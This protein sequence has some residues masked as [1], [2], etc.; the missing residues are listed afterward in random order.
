MRENNMQPNVEC[1][2]RVC[3]EWRRMQVMKFMCF[4]KWD[5]HLPSLFHMHAVVALGKMKRHFTGV[6]KTSH[7]L[8][9]KAFISESMP[10]SYA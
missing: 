2:P 1:L 8:S 7:S 9:P 4:P 3:D 6:V 5:R 10:S